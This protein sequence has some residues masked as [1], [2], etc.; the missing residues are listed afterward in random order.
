MIF[1]NTEGTKKTISDR[2]NVHDILIDILN[3]K[4]SLEMNRKNSKELRK[5]NTSH[6]YERI[7]KTINVSYRIGKE[8]FYEQINF[9]NFDNGDELVSIYKTLNIK[10]GKEDPDENN[11]IKYRINLALI[12]KKYYTYGKELTRFEKA[13]AILS[14]NKVKDLRKIAQGD[15]MLMRAE[16]KIEE[17]TNNP[18]LVRYIDDEKAMEFGHKLDVEDAHK[19]GI[20]ETKT[21]TAKKM[22]E[23]KLPISLI[24]KI[25]DLS[26]D[27]IKN[28]K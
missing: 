4:V 9:D 11:F 21:E 24:S 18:E 16:K 3:N 2:V 27:E 5:R 19:K 25:T 8:L 17:L 20:T 6:F 22:L 26:K 15:D 10:N 28:L 12:Y 14:F 7:C 23:E 13:L 1:V